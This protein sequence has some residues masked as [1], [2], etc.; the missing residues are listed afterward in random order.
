MVT[1]QP[2]DTKTLAQNATIFAT[3]VDGKVETFTTKRNLVCIIHTI[4]DNN[5]IPTITDNDIIPTDE[6]K[7]SIYTHLRIETYFEDGSTAGVIEGPTME[8]GEK[9]ANMY[10]PVN[11]AVEILTGVMI[12][13]VERSHLKF[14]LVAADL[15]ARRFGMGVVN[16]FNLPP[17]EEA[18][19]FLESLLGYVTTMMTNIQTQNGIKLDHDTVVEIVNKFTNNMT[20]KE[21]AE[22]EK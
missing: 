2:D 21:N 7:K 9:I 15:G 3:D 16:D 1:Q 10:I 17:P 11:D 20:N 5:I 13:L 19:R 8:V 22:T 4:T 12:E 18:Y 14:G 6:E